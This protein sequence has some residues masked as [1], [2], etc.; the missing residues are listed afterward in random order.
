MNKAELINAISTLIKEPKSKCKKFL[1]AYVDTVSKTLKRGKSVC[2]TN[3]GTIYVV[4]RKARTGVNPSTKK[5]MTI[6]AKK[7]VKL[8]V[9]KKLKLLVA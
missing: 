5:R 2:L 3:F 7:V 9:G 4:Q 6:P 8:K 1:E